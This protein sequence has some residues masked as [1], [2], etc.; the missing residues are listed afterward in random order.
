MVLVHHFTTAVPRQS[1]WSVVDYT[2]ELKIVDF[3]PKGPKMY[4]SRKAGV[5]GRDAK[6]F[7]QAEWSELLRRSREMSAVAPAHFAV[8]GVRDQD[9]VDEGSDAG[10]EAGDGRGTALAQA[11]DVEPSAPPAPGAA[12]SS[13]SSVVGLGGFDSLPSL[14]QVR[15]VLTRAVP[16][17]ALFFGSLFY[18]FPRVG[19]VARKV[20]KY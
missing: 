18:A 9:I 5:A 4:R 17:I 1:L 14:M 6:R 16:A 11:P 19:K 3:G 12:G 10:S 13:A 2:N 7:S 15:A 8:E 20:V